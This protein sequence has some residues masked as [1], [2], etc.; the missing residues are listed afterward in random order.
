MSEKLLEVR[1]LRKTFPVK[2]GPFSGKTLS[3]KAV[4]GVDM[5]IS[6]G[7]TLGLVGES[8]CGKTTVGRCL[9]RLY[10]P[11]SGRVFLDPDQHRPAITRTEELDGE[12]AQ[13]LLRIGELELAPPRSR[14][15]RAE[16]RSLQRAARRLQDRAD[17]E[18]RSCDI[19][20]MH[21]PDLKAA[22]RRIQMVFQ[23]PWA[24][25]NPMMLV[26]DLIA[27][28]PR[29]FGT[30]SGPTL[31]RW[32]SEL[33]DKVGLP[34]AAANRYPHE[35]S[36]GQRQRIGIARALAVTP[37]LIVCDEPVSALDVSIQAQV[38][39]L[40]ISLQD[41]FDLTYVFIAH[42]LSV[43]QYISDRV[44]VMYLGKMV[45]NAAAPQLYAQ[46]RHPYTISL[47]SSVPVA[48]PDY[49]S[50]GIILQGDV[51]SPVSP[52][53]GCSFHPRC[54]YATERCRLE[55]PQLEKDR[56]GHRIACHNPPN[57]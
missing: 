16:L 29:E 21:R 41:D 2:A 33:L 26:K 56:D 42:D 3:L 37:S 53:S 22:R 8:G 52:P 12:R 34:R 44:A 55:T 50:E 45:E 9:L 51:P 38:L 40:L 39:N 57:E 28:G 32:V 5:D 25:L 47:L 27:E 4:D 11:D 18:A 54:R 35:F 23:D 49:Q 10:E 6:R 1:G 30:H 20:S 43:V 46:P 24:S 14:V 19:L 36:G 17:A 48:D 7:E 15:G 13:K 31:D